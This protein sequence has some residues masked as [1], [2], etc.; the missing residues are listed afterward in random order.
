MWQLRAGSI[1]AGLLVTTITMA[2]GVRAERPGPNTP[3]EKNAE[4]APEVVE[5]GEPADPNQTGF[6]VPPDAT[7]E[8]LLQELVPD[9]SD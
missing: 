7:P 6:E 9:R 5:R 1:L 3:A 4:A 8:S 2:S